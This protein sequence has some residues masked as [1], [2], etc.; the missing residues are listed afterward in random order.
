[1]LCYAYYRCSNHRPPRSI[2]THYS[3][4]SMWVYYLLQEK[5]G[6]RKE[7]IEIGIEVFMVQNWKLNILSQ[8]GYWIKVLSQPHR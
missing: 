7:E 8:N 3:I 6:I 5:L 2:M 4:L 1:V